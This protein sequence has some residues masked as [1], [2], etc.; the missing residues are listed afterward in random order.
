MGFKRFDEGTLSLILAKPKIVLLAY[1]I[2]NAI[3][4]KKQKGPFHIFGMSPIWIKFVIADFFT[5]A[6]REHAG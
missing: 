4:V 2:C 1:A 3:G 6:D 5:S